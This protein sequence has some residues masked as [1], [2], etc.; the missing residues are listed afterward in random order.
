[1]PMND[2][3]P[4]PDQHSWQNMSPDE[5]LTAL[6]RELYTPVS[7][8]GVDLNRLT[9]DTDALSEDEADQI[10]EQMQSAVR[11]LSMTV[12]HLKR[13][14]QDRAKQLKDEP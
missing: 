3:P 5:V 10:F 4:R 8:L 7:L 13:Y 6:V 12:F 2:Q 14:T 9:G 11:Q 1:M